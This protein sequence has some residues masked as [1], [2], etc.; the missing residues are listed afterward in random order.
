MGSKLRPEDIV[1]SEPAL[2]IKED[3]QTEHGRLIL[4]PLRLLFIKNNGHNFLF[5]IAIK[6][7]RVTPTLEIALDT[8]NCVAH[9][10][11]MVDKNILSI[12][13]LQY[14]HAR[15]TVLDCQAWEKALN[16]EQ[17]TAHIK[18]AENAASAERLSYL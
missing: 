14:R 2:W 10:A 12:C 17:M 7:K 9:E 6:N 15:F 16:M 13:Y 3:G 8:I 11:L 4:T 18:Y 5:W 1:K